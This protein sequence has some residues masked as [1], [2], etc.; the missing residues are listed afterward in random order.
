MPDTTA[1][2]TV[3]AAATVGRESERLGSQAEPRIVLG[4]TFGVPAHRTVAPDVSPTMAN[5]G[6]G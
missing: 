6:T 3:G 4:V 1:D 2:T 5:H